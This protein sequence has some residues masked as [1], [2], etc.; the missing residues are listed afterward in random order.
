MINSTSTNKLK[1]IVSFLIFYLLFGCSNPYKNITKTE[2]TGQ[3]IN[4]IPYS[5]P[6]S[7][8][9]LIYKTSIDFYQ[10]NISGLLIIKKTDAQTY[11]IVLTTQFGLK[12][13]DFELKEGNLKVVYCIDYLNKKSVISTFQDDFSLL[14]MQNKF[15]RIYRFKDEEKSYKAWILQSGKMH[16]Y[17]FMNTKNNQIEKIE[18][19]KRNAKK[20]SVNLDGYTNNLPSTIFLK[21]H[22]I[23]LSLKLKQIQ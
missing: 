4:E 12:I 13:F 5:L 23:K 18:Q 15:N 11:R 21:H 2:F 16:Y 17:Y 8:K 20:I 3:N 9:T 6:Q 22:N 19:W 10:R 7:E 1:I 14:L